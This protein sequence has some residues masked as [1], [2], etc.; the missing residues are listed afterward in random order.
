VLPVENQHVYIPL[1]TKIRS[2]PKLNKASNANGKPAAIQISMKI[3]H[4]SPH[5]EL[6]GIGLHHETLVAYLNRVPGLENRFFRLGPASVSKL[7]KCLKNQAYQ[8]L[9]L[10]LKDYDILHIQHEY[11]FFGQHDLN[12]ILSLACRNHVKTCITMHLAPSIV[13]Q[14]TS[15]RI[16]GWNSGKTFIAHRLRQRQFNHSFIKPVSKADA[17]IVHN[18][19]ALTE[20]T[21]LGVRPSRIN[22]YPLP[23]Q[24]VADTPELG[25]SIRSQLSAEQS[26]IVMCMIGFITR[27]K[28]ILDGLRSLQ[29]LPS[30]Y[31]LAIIG[32]LHPNDPTGI[33]Y[34]DEIFEEAHR[35]GLTSRLYI[36]GFVDSDSDMQAMIAECNLCVMPLDMRYYTAQS[37]ASINIAFAHG[38]P[39]VGYPVPSLVELK[40]MKAP[41]VLSKV[42]HPYELAREIMSIDYSKAAKLAEEYAKRYSYQSLSHH[43][44]ELYRSLASTKQAY[45]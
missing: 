16:S 17:V 21:K 39:V 4:Y 30:S 19:N 11:S 35:F 25:S 45:G 7:D 3:L 23:V 44:A 2:C 42:S 43:I 31:K 14:P 38:I 32:G 10:A 18:T 33:G 26:D 12:I 6:C 22:I 37:S 29:F 9:G 28:G 24:P 15:V 8:E 13:Y 40:D 36:S 27:P 1:L 20:L 41:V 34:L 5:G